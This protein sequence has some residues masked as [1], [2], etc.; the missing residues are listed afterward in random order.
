LIV[1]VFV[2]AAKTCGKGRKTLFSGMQVRA[3]SHFQS[4][5]H[6]IKPPV[7]GAKR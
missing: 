6:T 4:H 1:V 7:A 2:P 5:L 3:Q